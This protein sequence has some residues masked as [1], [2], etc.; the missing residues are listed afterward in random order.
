LIVWWM[1]VTVVF[2]VRIELVIDMSFVV[3]ELYQG[4]LTVRSQKNDLMKPK[5]FFRDPSYKYHTH[6]LICRSITFYPTNNLQLDTTVIQQ[7]KTA[8][9]ESPKW[10]LLWSVRLDSNQRPLDP[11]LI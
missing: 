7:N 8:T 2:V 3:S 1:G 9:K 6:Y 11:Q 4:F 5:S 10:L